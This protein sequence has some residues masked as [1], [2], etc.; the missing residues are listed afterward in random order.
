M[1][2]TTIY[3]ASILL[4]P[5][6]PKG[7]ASTGVFCSFDS[8]TKKSNSC[9]KQKDLSITTLKLCRVPQQK[10]TVICCKGRTTAILQ[11]MSHIDFL[12]A[13]YY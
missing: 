5:F 1:S 2:K 9:S 13:L 3:V 4:F 8:S 7:D 10:V 6:V 11:T 12:V